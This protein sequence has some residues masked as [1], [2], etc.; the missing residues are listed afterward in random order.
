[1]S[2]LITR[3]LKT[4]NTIGDTPIGGVIETPKY[5]PDFDGFLTLETNHTLAAS[6]F[7]AITEIVGILPDPINGNDLP[8]EK[9]SVNTTAHD[10]H[11]VYYDEDTDLFI[12]GTS[13]GG[14]YTAPDLFT[15]WTEVHAPTEPAESAFTAITKFAGTYYASLKINTNV[16]GPELLYQAQSPAGPWS[17]APAGNVGLVYTFNFTTGNGILGGFSTWWSNVAFSNNPSNVWTEYHRVPTPNHAIEVD[18]LWILVSNDG[19]IHTSTNPFSSASWLQNNNVPNFTD[20]LYHILYDAVSGIYTAHSSNAYWW[21]SDPRGL[22]TRIPLGSSASHNFTKRILPSAQGFYSI[23]AGG[24]SLVFYERDKP[25]TTIFSVNRDTDGNTISS[26]IRSGTTVPGGSLVVAGNGGVAYFHEP[27]V[28]N[29]EEQIAI[30]AVVH[31]SSQMK[32]QM[33]VE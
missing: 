13:S 17:P 30:G 33:R 1:M 31:A 26:A 3:G 21:A 23:G 7:P 16:S 14:I 15:N 12:F 18:G 2:G 6:A 20:D 29:P 9:V 10:V 27:F 25:N 32:Y 22:W 24:G 4:A 11:G 8:W 28:F 5:I 19:G